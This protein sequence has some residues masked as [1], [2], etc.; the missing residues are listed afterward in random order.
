MTKFLTVFSLVFLYNSFWSQDLPVD[1]LFE[2]QE[3][4]YTFTGTRV[5]NGH[6]VDMLPK[7]T[8]EFRIEHKFGDI[9]GTNGGVQSMFGFDNLSDMRI[10]LE[11]GVTDKLMLG[12]GRCKGAGKP[13][14][15]LLDG[16]VKYS[17]LKQKK[18]KSFVSMSLIGTAGFTYMTASNDQS[19]VSNFTKF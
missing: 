18:G 4:D 12:F 19:L 7:G 5:I 3:L 8:M 14:R 1:T 2:E 11:Y 6:S 15:S 17:M 10:A 16:Y 9:A 13:Y